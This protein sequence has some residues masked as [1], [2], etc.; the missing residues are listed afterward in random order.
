MS[1]KT[2]L[3]TALLMAALLLGGC[4]VAEPDYAFPVPPI[5]P[6]WHEKGVGAIFL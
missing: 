6:R 4:A 2:R 5:S 3:L 1:P